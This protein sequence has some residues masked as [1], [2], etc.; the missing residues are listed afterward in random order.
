MLKLKLFQPFSACTW[1][2]LS[3]KYQATNQHIS[4]IFSQK[5]P[6]DIR[7]KISL[8]RQF[9]EDGILSKLWAENHLILS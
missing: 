8:F 1:S 3:V 2:Y 5:F 4:A 9:S 6:R 7:P